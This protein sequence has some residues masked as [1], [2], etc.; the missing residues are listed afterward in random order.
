MDTEDGFQIVQGLRRE[1]YFEAH[2]ST[3][4][5]ASWAGM[6]SLR[7]AC[8]RAVWRPAS[9]SIWRAISA[10]VISSGS[11][12][13]NSMTVSRLLILRL[14]ITTKKMQAQAD[15]STEVGCETKFF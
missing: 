15:L 4:L 1:N 9:H 7:R 14:S 5:R 10:S 2:V 3:S 13:T 12:L 8:S 6:P 11:L